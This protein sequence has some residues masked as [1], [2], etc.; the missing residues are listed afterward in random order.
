[1]PAGHSKNFNGLHFIC[2]THLLHYC[3]VQMRAYFHRHC[4]RA[5]AATLKL[6]ITKTHVVKRA[7][8]NNYILHGFIDIHYPGMIFSRQ[9]N[10]F[11]I[12]ES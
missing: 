5:A 9:Y 1:M 11:A 10:L 2:S 8:K 3:P 7:Q 12:E 6:P 4:R